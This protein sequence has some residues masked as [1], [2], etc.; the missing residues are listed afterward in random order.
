MGKVSLSRARARYICVYADMI[1]TYIY[2][3]I[4]RMRVC[5]CIYIIC[6]QTH[7]HTHTGVEAVRRCETEAQILKS[8]PYTGFCFGV[9]RR[10]PWHKFSKVLHITTFFF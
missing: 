5:V 1:Y 4:Y 7:T 3:Y 10:M 9:R 6:T 8:N 2:I